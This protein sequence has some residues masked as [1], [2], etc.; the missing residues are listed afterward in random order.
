MGRQS[1]QRAITYMG[2]K[3]PKPTIKEGERAFCSLF[4]HVFL[5]CSEILT[6]FTSLRQDIPLHT[7]LQGM[8]SDVLDTYSGCIQSSGVSGCKFSP[9]YYLLGCSGYPEP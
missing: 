5:L 2:G 9:F 4:V 6:V 8:Q 3:E 1:G 7:Q